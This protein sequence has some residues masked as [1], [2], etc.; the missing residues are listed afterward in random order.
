MK[1]FLFLLSPLALLAQ[2]DLPGPVAALPASAASTGV[3]GW[4]KTQ[5]FKGCLTVQDTITALT[6]AAVFGPTNTYWQFDRSLQAGGVFPTTNL[7]GT[8]GGCQTSGTCP[9]GLAAPLEWLGLH[10][11]NIYNY[12][13]NPFTIYSDSTLI[14]IDAF[15]AQPIQFYTSN[16]LRGQFLSGGQFE[17]ANMAGSGN[18]CARVNS[19]GDFSPTSGD[20]IDPTV[21]NTFTATQTFSGNPVSII[22]SSEIKPATG[23]GGAPIVHLGET[24]AQFLDLFVDTIYN[25]NTSGSLALIANTLPIIVDTLSNQPIEF[26]TQNTLRAQVTGTGTWQVAGMGGS[27][28]RCAQ[29]DNSGNFSVAAAGCSS[30][31]GTV[32]SPLGTNRQVTGGLSGFSAGVRIISTPFSSFDT[33][34]CTI[35]NVSFGPTTETCQVSGISGGLIQFTS[36]VPG[37]SQGFEWFALGF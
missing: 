26:F 37:S 6:G 18:R 8:I 3:C 32:T 36:S 24:T 29:V 9:G 15:S 12:G 30:G 28:T 10:V 22:I 2:T 33:I 1:T 11:Q 20:C 13:A 23:G 25:Y 5:T 19:S 7:T 4:N 31:S 35:L 21:P 34:Q 14:A 27:G 17:L 16:T